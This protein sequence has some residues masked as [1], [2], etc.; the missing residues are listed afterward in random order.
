MKTQRKRL[1]APL[2]NKVYQSEEELHR[3]MMKD[4][5]VQNYAAQKWMQ[6]NPERL[7]MNKLPSEKELM[8]IVSRFLCSSPQPTSSAAV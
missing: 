4:E 3:E 6:I 7:S 2:P 5:W 8:Q 1:Q